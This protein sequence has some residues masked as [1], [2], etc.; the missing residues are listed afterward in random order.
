MQRK[1]FTSVFLPSRGLGERR[2]TLHVFSHSEVITLRPV[3][4]PITGLA[5]FYR[6]TETDELRRWGFDCTLGKPVD[7]DN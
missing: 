1:P 5:H 6:C 3:G 7:E 2:A 4:G